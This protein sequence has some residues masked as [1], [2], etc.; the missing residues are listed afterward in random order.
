MDTDH[1]VEL[2]VLQEAMLQSGMCQVVAVLARIGISR[3]TQ[4]QAMANV[5]NG[6]G[7]LIF[8]DSRINRGVSRL[9]Y[10]SE[11]H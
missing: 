2:Q 3:A 8:L 10:L 4:L 11:T 1:V 7:N 9:S 5:I 6:P